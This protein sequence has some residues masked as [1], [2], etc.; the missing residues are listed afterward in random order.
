MS[1]YHQIE[2]F[3][4]TED[5][6][7]VPD[8]DFPVPG[9]LLI[10]SGYMHLLQKDNVSVSSENDPEAVE[11]QEPALNDESVLSIE[12][13]SDAPQTTCESGIATVVL[14]VTCAVSTQA[15]VAPARGEPVPTMANGATF[16]GVSVTA[17]VM[18]D[19]SQP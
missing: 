14:T 9:Y 2:R 4:P 6:P 7:N 8:H 16:N 1:R 5:A 18:E 13:Q 15:T 17:M 3:H 11:Y 12:L 10:P 19:W